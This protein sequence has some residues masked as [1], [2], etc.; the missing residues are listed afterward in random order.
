M[1][2]ETRNVQYWVCQNYFLPRVKFKCNYLWR[3]CVIE[4]TEVFAFS[5]LGSS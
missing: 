1:K 2:R 5:H 4:M 3:R